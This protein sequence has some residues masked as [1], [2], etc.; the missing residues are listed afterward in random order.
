M[1][2]K[3][4]D[5]ICKIQHITKKKP[6]NRVFKKIILIIFFCFLVIG[7]VVD[8]KFEENLPPILNALEVPGRSE[9]LE[10]YVILM[11]QIWGRRG[12]W[13][14]RLFVSGGLCGDF[15]NFVWWCHEC[16]EFRHLRKPTGETG[17]R[18]GELNVYN[19]L[20]CYAGYNVMLKITIFCF[21]F[22]KLEINFNAIFVLA[23]T[24]YIN[25][26]GACVN[27]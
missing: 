6:R 10:S 13:G 11:I 4:K 26:I 23:G 16:H 8:V 7:A 21:Y 22:V 15:L 27:R 24:N 12:T 25:N 19:N 1:G 9:Y 20:P 17:E 2:I 3:W 5:L 14:Q 18:S